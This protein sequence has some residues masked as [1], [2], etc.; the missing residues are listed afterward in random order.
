MACGSGMHRV[1]ES[2]AA[3]ERSL[4]LDSQLVDVQKDSTWEWAEDADI[5]VTHTHFPSVMY[6]RLRKP[7]R[8]VWVG[9]GTP[10]HVFH[11]AAEDAATAHYG[12]GDALMLMQ[13]W[14]K[15]SDARV[16]FWPRHKWVY[17]RMLT[18]GARPTDCLPLGVDRAFWCPGESAGKFVGSPSVL[19]SENPHYFKWPYDLFTCWSDVA[20]AV[21][22]V[23]LHA[24]YLPRDMHRVFF[25]WVNALGAHYSSYISA[26]TYDHSW[27]R[28][29][30]RSAD[31]YCGLVRYGDLNHIALQA[32]AAGIKTISYAGNPHS[33]FWVTEGDQR[34]LAAQLI[35]I[36]R[37]EVAPRDKSPVPDISETARA[38]Q[39]VYEEIA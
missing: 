5:H 24:N 36:L 3:A 19:T 28:N 30:F 27:L 26:N 15:V 25:P 2:I 37:G 32:N 21:P 39:R 31:F 29:A 10:D 4:G 22:T 14:L 35:A 18:R 34:E 13:H 17:D 20:E 1:A 33:D 23:Q 6:G 16:T 11:S 38:M 9:H 12:H 8:M 7:R